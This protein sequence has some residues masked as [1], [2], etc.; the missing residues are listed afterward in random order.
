MNMCRPGAAPP[1]AGL[2]PVEAAFLIGDDPNIRNERTPTLRTQ[3]RHSTTNPNTSTCMNA[4]L[5]PPSKNYLETQEL[6]S[7]GAPSLL[8]SENSV[9]NLEGARSNTFELRVQ[10]R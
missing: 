7:N 2:L 1:L 10:R 8:L 4:V 6:R 9:V 3:T 5:R